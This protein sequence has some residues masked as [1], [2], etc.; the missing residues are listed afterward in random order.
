MR[1]TSSCHVRFTHEISCGDG[2]HQ[3][4]LLLIRW[5]SFCHKHRAAPTVST[6]TDKVGT[7]GL[8]P[9]SHLVVLLLQLLLLFVGNGKLSLQTQDLLHCVKGKKRGTHNR[10]TSHHK[11]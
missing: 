3:A 10:K 2:Y 1:S 9:L 5:H 6:L 4:L 8:A 7:I 11:P